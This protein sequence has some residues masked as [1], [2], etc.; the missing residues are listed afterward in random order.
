MA[1]PNR[2]DNIMR[3]MA[4]EIQLLEHDNR[5]EAQK[6]VSAKRKKIGVTVFWILLAFMAILFI[7]VI[8]M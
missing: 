2:S 7:N 1:L 3:E 5:R 8:I 6:E 4:R